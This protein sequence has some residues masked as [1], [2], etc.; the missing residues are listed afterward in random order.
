MNEA[1]KPPAPAQHQRHDG[2]GKNYAPRNPP[3]LRSRHNHMNVEEAQEAT[4]VVL[5]M[6]LV[7]SVL[8][9]VL[10]DSG[11]SHSFV[12]ESFVDKSG[13]QQTPLKISCQYKY[14][15]Q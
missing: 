12:T 4:D 8:A 14:L 6:F 2:N 11:A 13:L 15:G 9:R 5:G 7:N 3:N 1:P 10:F